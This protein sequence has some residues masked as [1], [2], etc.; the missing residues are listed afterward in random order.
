[1]ATVNTL[2]YKIEVLGT[3]TANL[4]VQELIDRQKQL[5]KLLAEIP[6]E[7]TKAYQELKKQVET[8]NKGTKT[9]EQELAALK[10]QYKD[11]AKQVK[12]FN[13]SLEDSSKA[14]EK[15][16]RTAEIAI[17]KRV[18]AEKRKSDKILQTLKDGAEQ[19]R[20]IELSTSEQGLE[21]LRQEGIDRLK[22]QQEF[23]LLSEKEQEANIA[24]INARYAKETDK[25]AEKNAKENPAK[26][27][28]NALRRELIA[29]NKELDNTA[30]EIDGQVN[31]AFEELTRKSAALTRQVSEAEQA[32]GRFQRNVGNYPDIGASI[33][34]TFDN[35]GPSIVGAFAI[36]NVVDLAIQGFQSVIAV[37]SKF[38]QSISNLS[39]ITGATGKDLDFIKNKAQELGITSTL[40]ASATA[41]AFKVIGSASPSLLASGEALAG[42]TE[43][44]I[45]LSQASGDE[46]PATAASLTTVLNQFAKAGETAQEQVIRAGKAVDILAAASQAGSAEVGD[47]AESLK[48]AGVPANALGLS[49]ETTVGALETLA[50]KTIKAEVAG[51]AFKGTLIALAKNGIGMKDGV[52]DLNAALLELEPIQS[53]VAAL[54]K[55]FGS[56]NL[57]AAQTLIQ[58]REQV[59]RY[60]DAVGKSG[61]ATEQ[62]R[63][64]MDNLAGDS[65]K[66]DAALEGIQLTIFDQ[67]GS[68]TRDSIQ[69]FTKLIDFI[70][71]GLKDGLDDLLSPVQGLF[72]AFKGLGTTLSSFYKSLAGAG[73][74]GNA[75]SFVMKV[76]SKTLGL[77]M[78]PMRAIVTVLGFIAKGVSFAVD[79]I[80]GFIEESPK[81]QKAIEILSYPLRVL[82]EGLSF[83]GNALGSLLGT[84]TPEIKS[85]AAILIQTFGSLENAAQAL[86]T[87]LGAT[88]QEYDEFLKTFDKTLLDGKGIAEARQIVEQSFN[89]YLKVSRDKQKQVASEGLQA[90]Q[91]QLSE[92]EELKLSRSIKGLDELKKRKIAELKA[93][94]GFDKL[95]HADQ[96]ILLDKLEREF[97]EKKKALRKTGAKDEIE[98]ALKTLRERLAKEQDAR[99]QGTLQGLEESRL[100]AIKSLEQEKGFSKL[101]AEEQDGLRKTINDDYAKRAEQ[102]RLKVKE[103]AEKSLQDVIEAV[104]KRIDLE[105]KTEQAVLSEANQA[106]KQAIDA[107]EQ[108]E[109]QRAGNNL[110]RR[111]KVQDDFNE[112]R[113]QL[114]EDYQREQIDLQLA[115]VEAQLKVAGLGMDEIL[116]LEM[117]QQELRA[118]LYELDR[119]NLAEAE[120]K[121]REEI[122]R[123]LEAQKEVAK[124]L[125]S[126]IGTIT[127]VIQD[128]ADNRIKS[129]NALNEQQ[130][131]QNDAEVARINKEYEMRKATLEANI[132]NQS[133]LQQALSNL[134]AQRDASLAQVEGRSVKEKEIADKQL[135]EEQ[136]RKQQALAFQKRVDAL[137]SLV[138]NAAIVRKGIL[139]ILEGAKEPFPVNLIAIVSTIAAVAAG[140]ANIRTLTQATSKFE[141]GGEVTPSGVPA[142]QKGIGGMHRGPRH[143]HGGV[144]IEVEGGEFEVNREATRMFLPVIN[145][146][147]DQGI[148]KM[149]GGRHTTDIT[150]AFRYSMPIPIPTP[151]H[152]FQTGGLVNP[153][154]RETN[155]AVTQGVVQ[156]SDDIIAALSRVESS[157]QRQQ[158]TLSTKELD[159]SNVRVS[160]QETKT[161]L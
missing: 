21:I 48:K 16:A 47:I 105:L 110:S 24:K 111:L 97:A 155:S 35:I 157:I 49:L 39:A 91:A 2:I 3:D 142:R 36:G 107:A 159:R 51:T 61:I 146:M 103:D 113:L 34:E 156:G 145:W 69:G 45:L 96:L 95:G 73:G 74:Q 56:E 30:H 44:A 131:A 82:G 102:L 128:S 76:L 100:A 20:R 104:T 125:M 23:F 85:N 5:K 68:G 72:D 126:T 60:T 129:L 143:S 70:S 43:Q 42:V 32:S 71:V 148:K 75:L 41:E 33:K 63:I 122:Q 6:A 52:L 86:R 161:R 93:S 151:S 158:L 114:D 40:G 10:Q 119:Q 136:D 127:S 38:E 15:A 147:N 11:S 7:S 77:A 57:V 14:E 120:E 79:G 98:E 117:Q 13:K 9:L 8:A 1:M 130:K 123:T 140:I 153:I 106:R 133:Q 67:I 124:G 141:E 62:A 17:Q 37:G 139:A 65:K 31:P 80:K 112:Q 25:L 90:L 46:L 115:A 28:T 134:D 26:G 29:L 55:L 108:E 81:L 116:T 92:E 53:D 154:G 66:L 138:E 94:E 83:V 64:N 19:Q 84:A 12:D 18:D 87:E 4:S 22:A 58:N 144:R 50:D 135:K 27:S 137:Q 78:L 121:K 118:Q 88:K 99:R 152:R 160:G 101:K 109:L 89:E 59:L 54:T 132:T 149:R 150:E